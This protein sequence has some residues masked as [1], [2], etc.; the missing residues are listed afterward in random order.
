MKNKRHFSVERLMATAFAATFIV[1][2]GILSVIQFF[3]AR[4]RRA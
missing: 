1:L 3:L 4:D 2:V